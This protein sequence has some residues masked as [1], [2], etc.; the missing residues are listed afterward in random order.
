MNQPDLIPDLRTVANGDM[1]QD[2]PRL[3]LPK[4]LNHAIIEFRLPKE[5]EPTVHAVIIKWADME[6]R[7]RLS[8]RTETEIE[9]EF[10]TE[11]FG[12]V[13]GYT[14]FSED[15]DYW[16]LRP[17]FTVP[18]GTA[19]AAIGRFREQGEEQL[20]ALVELKGPMVNVDRDRFNGRTPVQQC[21]EYLNARPD[22]PWG[23]VC[24]YV[25]FRLYHRDKGSRAYEH[26]TLQELRDIDNFRKFRLLFGRQGL[27]P[28]TSAQRPLLVRLLQ[29]TGEQ[30]REVGETLYRYYHEQRVDLIDHLC[31]PPHSKALDSAIRIAQKLVDRVIFVAFCEDR[32]LLPEKS[33]EKAYTHTAA[34]TK[35]TNPK[36]QGFL[37]LFR[38]IDEGNPR[39][40]IPPFDGGLFAED[41]EVD[42]L[43]LGDDRTL[44]FRQIGEYDFRYEVNVDVL[45]HLFEHSIN[46]LERIRARGVFGERV[47][48]EARAPKMGKSAERKRGGIYYTPRE[49]TDLIVRRTVG[50]IIETRLDAVA[51]RHKVD[52]REAENAD[53]DPSL[54]R[55]WEDCFE[56]VR[57]IKVCDPACGSGAFLIRAYDLFADTYGDI[58]RNWGYH[59][60]KRAEAMEDEVAEII[61]GDNLYGVDLSPEAV[62]ITQLAL[63]IRSARPERT[64]T[65]LSQNIVCGNSLIDD[66]AVHPRA[67][68]WRETFAQVFQREEAG[69]DCVIGNPPWERM[70]LRDRE[71]FAILAPDVINV[72]NPAESRKRIA[73]LRET[74]PQLYDK[75]TSACE[76]ADRYLNYVHRCGL[77]PLAGKGDVNTYAVFA[78]LAWSILAPTGRAG[79]LVPSGIATDKTTRRFFAGL[80]K[81]RNLA[82]LYDFENKAPIF[83]DVH[84]SYKFCVLLFGGSD[85]KARAADF[86]FFAHRMEDLA[87]KDRHMLL[88]AADIR[89]LN[90][91]TRTCPIF[92]SGRDAELTKRIYRR[93]PVLLDRSRK[94]GANPWGAKFVRMFDQ[95]NDAGLFLSADQLKAEGCKQSGAYWRLGKKV[96]LPVYEAKMVQMYDHRAASVTTDL[97]NWARLG[98]TLSTS[99]V[100]HQNPEFAPIPRWWID[101]KEV[102]R[103]MADFDRPYHVAYK[104]VTSATNRR[105]MIAALVPRIGSTHPLPLV[106]VDSEMGP[107][108]ECC[109]LANLNSYAYDFVARQKVGGVHL[110]FFILEQL[111]TLPPDAYHDRCPWDRR[112]TLENWISDR[113]LKLTCTA[114]D[115]KPLARAAGFSPPVHKWKEDERDRLQAELDA[116]YF[117]LY[118]VARD[119]AEYILSTFQGTGAP[120][121]GLLDGLST[122][123]RVLA[124]YDRLRDRSA[125]RPSPP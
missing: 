47:P 34:F 112:Q 121:E 67:M 68:D 97:E 20:H 63:W 110:S 36:W 66:P 35:V 10:L 3:I 105:T 53:P 75:Y 118:G 1:R 17:K 115:M 113:V 24:N 46:D 41:P 89:L 116:A 125:R 60:P 4:L 92:R 44:F 23:I 43:Q 26:L 38:S 109:L 7:G 40:N 103:V 49:F 86:V 94:A 80:M 102:A 83:P 51:E 100:D 73:L 42:T 52:R 16:E 56:A 99:L 70:K 2:H 120:A 122:A 85:V 104:D 21:W 61:L 48:D 108:L 9:G 111:P 95:S 71:F 58:V 50:Q 106:I 84:R 27:L 8:A 101:E 124:Q 91:N 37:S 76:S 57:R 12:Q 64:L 90:P 18:G 87:R 25:G 55:Y 5:H 107:R 117:L 81:S 79:L 123:Q 33:L 78:E 39:S 15:R 6:S 69:F 13:L 74:N 28:L 82:A 59:D 93:V 54:A 45:G 32:R 65:D 11:V 19:D 29:E 114:N 14:L 88:T 119:D 62:E 22:C 96:L 30:Q 72:A 98:Q 77:Y 31:K